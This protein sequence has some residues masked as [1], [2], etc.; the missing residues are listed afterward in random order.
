[1]IYDILPPYIDNTWTKIAIPVG[2]KNPQRTY[3]TLAYTTPTGRVYEHTDFVYYEN[4]LDATM[5]RLR[6]RT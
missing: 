4:A 1:M 3:R 6:L 5:F 2:E